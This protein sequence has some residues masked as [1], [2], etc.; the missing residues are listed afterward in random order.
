[1]STKA[2]DTE[3]RRQKA[4]RRLSGWLGFAIE[5]AA[6]VGSG[7]VLFFALNLRDIAQVSWIVGGLLV[8]HRFVT[9][10]SIR[11]GQDQSARLMAQLDA[12]VDSTDRAHQVL[13]LNQVDLT[14]N[15][16]VLSKYLNLRQ[17]LSP[18]EL[19]ELVDSYQAVVQPELFT[20][21][22]NV[23]EAAKSELT[24]LS[25]NGRSRTLQTTEYYD[26]LLPQLREAKAGMKIWAVSLMLDC[27]WDDSPEEKEF[28]E[29][30]L[31]AAEHG[32]T[33]ER[34]FICDS[35]T[36]SAALRMPF[37]RRQ[38]LAGANFTVR[39]VDREKV[40]KRDQS[41]VG[42]AGDGFIAFGKSIALVDEHSQ[43][44][45]AR[46][47]VSM[48]ADQIRQLDRMFARLS[49]ASTIIGPDDLPQ[50]AGPS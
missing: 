29:L 21:R 19:R 35:D 38:V 23:V 3:S 9:E 20:L 25:R 17:A 39:H 10:L 46:G 28:L 1:M 34:I 16:E 32:A 36:W 31:R 42:L 47:H 5:L 11:E 41:I 30:N 43:D 4:Q 13:S 24:Q 48:D 37:L 2:D 22:D 6:S 33:V 50:S 45:T 14:T 44:G 27:E 40:Q 12:R 8:W 15:I 7:F 18:G 26:W 49:V